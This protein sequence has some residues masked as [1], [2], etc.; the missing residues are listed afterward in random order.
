M[1][2]DLYILPLGLD[3]TNLGSLQ[4]HNSSTQVRGWLGR[5]SL[6]LKFGTL[7][8]YRG[9][10]PGKWFQALVGVGVRVSTWL[11][12]TPTFSTA[13]SCH[14]DPFHAGN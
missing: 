6:G 7:M 5:L 9:I 11:V 14:P 8:S 10:M 2:L 1:A 4:G 3:N 13:L 12:P